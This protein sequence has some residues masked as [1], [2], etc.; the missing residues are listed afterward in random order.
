MLS[1]QQQHVLLQPESPGHV[2]KGWDRTQGITCLVMD[3]M[4]P[5]QD[6]KTDGRVSNDAEVEGSWK[7]DGVHFS[8]IFPGRDLRE[9]GQLEV[10]VQTKRLRS[11]WGNFYIGPCGCCERTEKMH[12]VHWEEGRKERLKV[13][14]TGQH[15]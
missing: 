10:R 1:H 12:S 9:R 4:L 14:V 6:T 7:G 2:K 11:V 13:T 3:D 8:R 5:D 15:P